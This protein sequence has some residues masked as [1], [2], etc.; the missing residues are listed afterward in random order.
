MKNAAA[1]LLALALPLRAISSERAAVPALPPPLPDWAESVR[2]NAAAASEADF[3]DRSLL[4]LLRAE[5]LDRFE[6]PPAWSA[7]RAAE[8]RAYVENELRL[9]WEGPARMTD[10]PGPEWGRAYDFTVREG[11]RDPFLVW[12]SVVGQHKWHWDDKARAQLSALEDDLAALPPASEPFRRLLAA[13]AR[14]LLDPEEDHARA[15]CAAAVRWAESHAAHPERSEAVLRVLAQFVDT[16]NSAL[17]PAFLHSSADPWI[18]F[19]LGGDAALARARE[20]PAPQA[21]D[22]ALDLAAASYRRAWELHPEFPQG[23]AGMAIISGLRRDREG[24]RLWFARAAEARFDLVRL[25]LDGGLRFADPSSQRAHEDACL[26]LAADKP[27]TMLPLCGMA[28]VIRELNAGGATA[29]A[30]LSD[31]GRLARVETALESVARSPDATRSF[32]W[33]AAELVAVLRERRGDVDGALQACDAALDPVA[34]GFL[35]AR[36]AG[37]AATNMRLGGISGPNREIVRPLVARFEAGD[38]DGVLDFWR[39]A[40]RRCVNATRNERR[41]LSDLSHRAFLHAR[42]GRGESRFVGIL[43]EG[44]FCEWFGHLGKD[45]TGWKL[46]DAPDGGAAVATGGE[47]VRAI[48]FRHPLPAEIEIETAFEVLPGEEGDVFFALRFLPADGL[49]G[50]L[51]GSQPSLSFR[52]DGSEGLAVRLGPSGEPEADKGCRA[53]LLA[54]RT[55][56]LPAGAGDAP[57]RIRLRAVFGDGRVALHLGD[58]PEPVLSEACSAFGPD[59]MP[60][61]GKLVFFGRGVRFRGFSFRKPSPPPPEKGGAVP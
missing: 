33:A 28:S 1:L 41:F 31:A 29:A 60:N 45:G 43:L 3:R 17:V 38:F 53:G 10:R 13:H 4:P 34:D 19:A 48:E 47:A 6:P 32:R 7:A 5:T 11:S 21:R 15:L 57:R 49:W 22:E 55:V 46:E 16:G 58:D 24:L 37:T 61:G 12:M 26:A 35:Q 40:W 42:F 18:A 27:G 9:A 8:A 23:A 51:R 25:H 44:E 56:P 59:A 2:T 20:A 39:S 36:V 54:E 52:S 30:L 50:V 14:Q